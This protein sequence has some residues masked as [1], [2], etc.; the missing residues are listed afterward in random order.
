M[1][2]GACVHVW[3]LFGYSIKSK[4]NN[5]NNSNDENKKGLVIFSAEFD[6]RTVEDLKVALN[7]MNYALHQLYFVNRF[8]KLEA[9]ESEVAQLTEQKQVKNNFQNKITQIVGIA[10]HGFFFYID[11][12]LSKV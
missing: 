2:G 8:Q 7:L 5:N 6:L 3:P 12:S 10:L 1:E 9:K 4:N 11:S